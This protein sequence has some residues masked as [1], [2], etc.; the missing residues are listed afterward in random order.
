MGLLRIRMLGALDHAAPACRNKSRIPVNGDVDKIHQITRSRADSVQCGII[1]A[2]SMLPGDGTVGYPRHLDDD[3]CRGNGGRLRS[4][5]LDR[6][7]GQELSA[8]VVVPRASQQALR[9]PQRAHHP[10]PA[11]HSEPTTPRAPAYRFG[12]LP[13]LISLGPS[14]MLMFRR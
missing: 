2:H 11:T 5:A 14:S 3:S 13:A 4:N 7:R 1:A 9:T 6:S 8:R 12:L 10:R